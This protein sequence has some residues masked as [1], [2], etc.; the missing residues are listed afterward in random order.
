[1]EARFAKYEALSRRLRDGLAEL[2]MPLF[3]PADMMSPVITAVY[4]PPGVTSDQIIR[5]LETEHHIKITAGFD[6]LKPRVIRI[7]HMGG[8]INEQDIDTLLAA[9]RE[10]LQT[11]H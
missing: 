2:D 4:C 11:R 3:V 9:L 8:A 1:L 6:K 10:Y 5:Y 7:G